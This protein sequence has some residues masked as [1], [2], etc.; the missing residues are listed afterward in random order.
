VKIPKLRWVIAAMLFLSTMINYADRLALSIVSRDLRTEFHLTEQDYSYIITAFFVAYAIMYAGS[1]YLVDRLGTRRGFVLFVSTWS[2][3]AMLHALVRGLWSLTVVRFLLGLS[4]PGNWPAAAK[5]VAEWFPPAQRALGVGIF[6]AGSSLGSAI[7]PPM[8]AYLTLRFGW[9]FAFLFTGSLGIL[10]LAGWLFLYQ[11]PHRNR[12]LLPKEY[13]RIKTEVRPPEEATP[14][15]PQSID[16]RKVIRM[17]ECYTLILARFFTD[18]V[19]YFVIFWF[20]EY[21]RKERG[22]DLKM[23]GDYAWVPFTVGGAGY[24]AGGWLS[25]RLMRAGWNL[26]NA[27][28][29]VMLLG[30]LLMPV[31]IFTPLVPGAALAIAATCFITVGHAFFVANVQT[32]PTD[33]FHGQEIGTASGFS[34]MGGAVGGI[35]ANLATGYIVQRFSYAPVFF[36][37]GL[38]HPLSAALVYWLLPNRYFLDQRG[39]DSQLR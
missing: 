7:A 27:R 22:F 20:P 24:L 12:W 39:S 37:A 8:V 2:V 16:W 14:A 38:M 32:M 11:P 19:I 4:E 36:L 9:R 33:L 26:P 13:E 23:V 29:F 34:G 5:A 21:L 18:P 1:G 17:R 30:A 15:T 28:K 35:L 25:G 6:N 3:A 31:S 10:W